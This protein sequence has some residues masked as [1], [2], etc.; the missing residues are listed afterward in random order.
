MKI[1]IKKKSSD[2]HTISYIREGY[3]DYWIEADNFLVIHDLCHFA[4]ETSLQYKNAFWG[5]VAN[6]INPSVFE[7][8]ETRNTLNL[9]NEAW[10]AE[11]L[12]NLL[13]IEF[14]QGKFDDFNQ[15]LNESIK[16][17]NPEIPLVN[18]SVQEIDDIRNN[19]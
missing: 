8:R 13:L 7:N 4:I 9:S 6:G 16:R 14:A 3:Q 5:L 18:Y 19:V 2:K 1:I 10:Y 12:A 17:H 15:V 11:H